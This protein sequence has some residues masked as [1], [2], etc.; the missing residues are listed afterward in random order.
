MSKLSTNYCIQKI[1]ALV[2][3]YLN[4]IASEE[5]YSYRGEHHAPGRD[6]APLHDLTINNIYPEDVY[7]VD[8]PRYYGIGDG[9]DSFTWS[10]VFSSKNKP[11]KQV[12][13]YR[14]VPWIKSTEEKIQEIE[15]KK[16]YILKHGKIPPDV[17]TNKNPYQYFDELCQELI[18]LQD[19]PVKEI[20]DKLKINPGDWVTI[21][22][23]YAVDH[24]NNVFGLKNYK[25]LSKTVP[26]SAVFT[27][28]DSILEWGYNP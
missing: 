1:D 9:T 3:V 10:I 16:R 19:Q 12:K 18:K 25:I 11:G 26:A 20:T 17:I 23:K 6:A 8:G 4:S 15:N 14:A 24:G 21:D 5:N 13:I 27:N 2:N 22:R 28:G 7:S